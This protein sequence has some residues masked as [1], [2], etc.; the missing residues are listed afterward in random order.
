MLINWLLGIE[1]ADKMDFLISD[2]DLSSWED[3]EVK[4]RR[5]EFHAGRRIK[6][7]TKFPQ[8]ETSLLN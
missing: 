7:T 4:I 2:Y 3:S 5:W 6:L 1:A 8:V